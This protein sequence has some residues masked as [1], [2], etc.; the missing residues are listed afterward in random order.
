MTINFKVGDIL[1]DEGKSAK[2]IEVKD[3]TIVLEWADGSTEEVIKSEISEEYEEMVDEGT[4]AANSLATH[5]SANS[6]NNDPKSKL[7][8]LKGVIGAAASLKNED[9]VKLYTSMM[10]QIGKET[11]KLPSGANAGSNAATIKAKSSAAVKEDMDAIFGDTDLSE[12]FKSKVTTLFEAAVASRIIEETVRLEEEYDNA[13]NEATSELED[14]LTEQ[15]N[16]YLDYVADKWLEGNTIAVESNLRN[17]LVENFIVGLKGLFEEN[18][19]DV[20]ED[21]VDV[22]EQ[23]FSE[24][25]EL[26]TKFNELVSEHIELKKIL[27]EAAK[28]EVFDTVKEGL[29]LTQLE[30]FKTLAEGIEFSDLDTYKSKLEIVKENYFV[31][32]T[33]SDTG[34]VDDKVEEQI[35]ESVKY[36]D[37][38]IAQFAKAITRSR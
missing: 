17:E 18:Y 12:D 21:K 27:E 5:S 25:E 15:L 3:T 37:P 23:L 32:T 9:L 14:V 35:N 33:K 8:Y 34:V 24:K 1:E 16:D 30:K 19:I 11:E 10:A 6:S 38:S 28:N 7:E 4:E 22:L 29:T 26:E 36:V 2:I 13:F 20:P 31:K